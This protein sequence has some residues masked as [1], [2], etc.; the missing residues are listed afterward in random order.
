M[1]LQKPLKHVCFD[2]DGTIVDS[3]FTIFKTT[4]NT[5]KVLKIKQ[6]L[7]EKEFRKRIG[8]HFIDIF[9]ELNIP[10][11]DFDEFI[12]IYKNLYFDYI[13]D[14]ALYPGVEDVM[15]YLK[16]KNIF[17]SLLTTKGQEQADRNIDYF[18]LR[19][20]FSYVM[21]RR[22]GIANKPSADPLIYIC[23]ELKAA[24]ENTMFVGDTEMDI[25]CGKNAGA[26]TCAVL[27]GYRTRDFLISENPDFSIAGI[28]EL[29][30][31]L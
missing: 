16:S 5:L 11:N 4:V 3:Y 10:V 18:G 8:H 9:R 26:K 20:Y 1:I 31:I 15:E 19:K 6:T 21:G 25:R 13:S 17:I 27:Y 23:N 2:L 22:S 14:A 12:N 30:S 24:P 7:D 29:K 28:S